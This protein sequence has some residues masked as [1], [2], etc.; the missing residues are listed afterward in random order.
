MRRRTFLGT[1]LAL[2]NASPLLAAVR[3]GR[4]D[5]AAGVLERAAAAKR[6][7]S[8]VLHVAHRRESFTR[9]FGK[10]TSGDAMF[11]LGSISKPINVTAVMTRFDRGEFRLDDRARKFLPA[12]AG[13]GRDGVT[14]RQ[15]LTHTSG[16]PDQLAD[17][18]E[19]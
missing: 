1:A 2:A 18:D 6:V 7:E 15:L 17:N 10:A 5:D 12:F 8:A 11:L 16:L 14:I 4:W 13:D 19:L 9:H 3:G